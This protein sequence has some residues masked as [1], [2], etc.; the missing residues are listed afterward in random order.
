MQ[1]NVLG[2][3]GVSLSPVNATGKDYGTYRGIASSWFNADMVAAED[4]MRDQ[5][6]AN[7]DYFR[8]LALQKQAQDFNA[9]EAEKAR[10]FQKELSDTSYQ[11]VVEDLKRAGL[12]PILAYSNGGAS[13]PTGSVASAS[14]GSGTISVSRRTSNNQKDPASEFLSL[15][16]GLLKAVTKL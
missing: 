8:T 5:Q 7:N 1:N 14:T 2:D 12:N 16:A 9:S 15:L 11:R 13:S 6:A 3:Y 10:Q 4:F